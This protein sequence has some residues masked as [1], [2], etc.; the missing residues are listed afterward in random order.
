LALAALTPARTRSRIICR[1]ISAKAA[2][3]CNRNFDIGLS[4]S[5]SMDSVWLR[6]RIPK[7]TSSWMLRTLD[8][9]LQRRDVGPHAP[10]AGVNIQTPLTAESRQQC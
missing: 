10:N 1:S 6:K 3:K 5:V 8:W 7:P 4:A 9:D 2:N